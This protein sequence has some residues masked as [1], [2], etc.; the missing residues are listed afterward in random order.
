MLTARL[1]AVVFSTRIAGLSLPAASI[2]VRYICVY[3][4]RRFEENTSQRPLGDQEC[5][6]FMGAAFERKRRAVPPC[7]GMMKSSL[8]G[9]IRRPVLASTKRSEEHTSELQSVRH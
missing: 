3:G 8:S 4:E 1:A 9:R 2:C 5:Q 6:E 7:A